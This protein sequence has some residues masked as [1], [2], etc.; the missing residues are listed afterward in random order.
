MKTSIDSSRNF[1]L[2]LFLLNGNYK[3]AQL[4]QYLK[5]SLH[6]RSKWMNNNKSKVADLANVFQIWLFLPNQAKE[7]FRE[8][9][10][11]LAGNK[12]AKSFYPV[13]PKDQSITAKQLSVF[14]T[15]FCAKIL[16]VFFLLPRF[17]SISQL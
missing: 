6:L 3:R 12:F 17:L 9:F 5:F 11:F 15:V 2:D 1:L 4:I 14:S 7:S 8:S 16:S 10:I 13:L